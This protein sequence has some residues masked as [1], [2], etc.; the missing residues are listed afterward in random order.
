MTI[1]VQQMSLTLHLL[2][3]V[4]HRALDNETILSYFTSQ[5]GHDDYKNKYGEAD[6][7]LSVILNKVSLFFSQYLFAQYYFFSLIQCMDVYIM[8][9]KPFDHEEFSRKTHLCTLMSKGCLACLLYSSQHLIA[10]VFPIVLPLK[11]SHTAFLVRMNIKWWMN[12]FHVVKLFLCKVIYT[13][14]VISMAKTISTSLKESN[15]LGNHQKNKTVHQRLYRFAL[16]PIFLNFVFLPY[17]ILKSFFSFYYFEMKDCSG[18]FFPMKVTVHIFHVITLSAASGI[19][20]A[21]YVFLF[22]NLRKSIQ[23]CQRLKSN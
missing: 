21:A 3:I 17:E 16:I 12:V 11:H 13:M 5:I 10:M 7:D 19:S 22:T 23:C 15:E 18:S 14:V 2:L 8:V 6:F 9:C 4:L 20:Y 1:L